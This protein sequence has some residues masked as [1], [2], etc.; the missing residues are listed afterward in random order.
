MY[1]VLRAFELFEP[2]TASEALQILFDYGARAKVLAGGVDLVMKMRLRKTEPEYVVSLKKIPELNGIIGDGVSGLR[3][4]ALAT[5]RSIEL[6]VAAQ[7]YFVL[8]QGINSISSI[9]VKNMG[10]AVGN[11]CVATPA[12]DV[13][14]PLFVLGAKLKIASVDGEK[15]IPIED[16]YEGVNK[17]VL[18]PHEIVTEIIIPG[19]SA[20]TGMAFLKIGKTGATVAKV[21]AAVLLVLADGKCTEARIALGAVAPTVIRAAKVEEVLKGEK[22]DGSLIEKAAAIAA[23]E[24][25]PI[26]DFR[27]TAEYRRLMVKA[28]VKE[29]LHKAVARAGAQRGGI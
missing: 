16:F 28:L 3:I 8:C 13:V 25:S 7:N 18:A 24:A 2:A 5:L 6:S 12:T 19:I 1:R 21:N 14:P 20:G 26:T 11:L 17:T 29:A 15:L 27:S 10:T 9:Q 4:G 22:V 23:D